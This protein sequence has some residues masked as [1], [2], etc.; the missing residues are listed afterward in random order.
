MKTLSSILT[1]TLIAA[2]A[3]GSTILGNPNSGIVLVDGGD[4][5]VHS[6]VA[7]RCSSGSQTISVKT[8]LTS[9]DKEAL[10]TFDQDRFC[11]M[12]VNV[13]W[14]PGGSLQTLPVGGFT[15]LDIQTGAA[16]V[17]IDLDASTQT[18]TLN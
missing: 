3:L 6:I 8:V 5:Y 16:T 14:T 15:Q 18:A 17:A 1:L 13:K 11:S 7:Y 12:D 4:T 10:F 9:E 2:P